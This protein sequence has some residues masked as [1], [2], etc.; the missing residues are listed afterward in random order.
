ME[1]KKI[2]IVGAGFIGRVVARLAVQHGYEVMLSNSRIPR[3][4]GA[5]WYPSAA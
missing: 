1:V 3:R 4:W 2:G 5:P